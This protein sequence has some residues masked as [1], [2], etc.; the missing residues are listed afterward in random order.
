[1]KISALPT[2]GIGLDKLAGAV[3]LATRIDGYE[4]PASLKEIIMG[5]T[6]VLPS[7]DAPAG[8]P[9]TPRES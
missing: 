7:G 5:Y 8:A 6:D 4:C 1:L 9:L 2:S 3:F